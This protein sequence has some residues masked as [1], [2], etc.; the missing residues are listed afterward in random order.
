VLDDKRW[1]AMLPVLAPLA[2]AVV[3]TRPPTGRAA[4]P[5]LVATAAGP[6]PRLQVVPE[7]AAALE[8]ARGLAGPDDTILVAGSLYL[9]GAVLALLDRSR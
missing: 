1:Q 8:T 5:A 3:V 6:H 4:D 7:P 9:V 2:A